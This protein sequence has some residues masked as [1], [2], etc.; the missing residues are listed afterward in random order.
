VGEFF[1][2]SLFV[3]L[4]GL[5]N[6]LRDWISEEVFVVHPSISAVALF[7]QRMEKVKQSIA[8]K[9]DGGRCNHNLSE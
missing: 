8:T 7:N 4:C 3:L 1:S 6:L 9:V 2:L 5:S